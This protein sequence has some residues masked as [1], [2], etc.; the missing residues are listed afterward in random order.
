MDR[1]S[2][3]LF[4]KICIDQTYHIVWLIDKNRDM[5][6]IEGI[7]SIIVYVLSFYVFK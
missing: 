2:K 5:E 1:K 7:D 6:I 3:Y 4:I